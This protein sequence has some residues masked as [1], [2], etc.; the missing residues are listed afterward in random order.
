MAVLIRAWTEADLENLVANA[1][2]IKIWNNWQPN[3]YGK[4]PNMN[5]T[6]LDNNPNGQQKIIT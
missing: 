5:L 1:N 2:N 4:Y 3:L 6:T